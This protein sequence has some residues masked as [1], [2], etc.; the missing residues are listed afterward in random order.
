MDRRIRPRMVN[1]IAISA[2]KEKLQQ[3]IKRWIKNQQKSMMTVNAIMALVGKIALAQNKAL[4]EELKGFDQID[5]RV[6]YNLTIKIN[7]RLPL[8]LNLIEEFEVTV[9]EMQKLLH[10][11]EQNFTFALSS[12]NKRGESLERE[13]EIIDQVCKNFRII[14]E[15]FETEL[16]LKQKIISIFQSKPRKTNLYTLYMT[17]WAAEPYVEYE[18][19]EELMEE[20]LYLDRELAQRTADAF[21]P[22]QMPPTTR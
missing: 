7:E 22:A 16:Q 20:S 19:I 9:F 11:I 18:K 2:Y 12:H 1:A 4:F 15:M 6:Q 8:L 13:V 17:V 5:V 3:L 21:D 14:T 10:R